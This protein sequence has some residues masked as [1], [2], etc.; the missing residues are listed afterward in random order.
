MDKDLSNLSLD[1]KIDFILSFR[2]ELDGHLNRVNSLA[3]VL[4]DVKGILHEI[5]ESTDRQKKTEYA[6]LRD[7]IA[8]LR[9]HLEASGLPKLD[10][11]ERRISFIRQKLDSP[12]WPVAVNPESIPT[13]EEDEH[14]RAGKIIDM[15]VHQ[16]PKD[17]KFLDF[18]CGAGYAV[19]A[20]EKREAA[21]AVGYDPKGG[22]RFGNSERVVFTKQM[23]EVAANGPYDIVLL[24]DVLDHLDVDPVGVLQSIVPHLNSQGRIYVRCHPWASKHGG[25]LYVQKNK[26]FLHLVLDEVELMRIGGIQ[27]DHILKIIRPLET[28]SE[29]FA[30]A[31]LKVMS[32]A[33][34]NEPMPPF[35]TDPAN[36]LI[37]GSIQKHWS[38]QDPVPHM[39][40]QYVDYVLEPDRSDKVIF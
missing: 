5:L 18:G 22:W 26:A 3:Q 39:T 19:M 28:Y 12:D 23:D 36:H 29:W 10:I 25:H 2:H 21:K 31:G 32:G 38:H 9:E 13:S 1:Q 27:S 8:I 34:R 35:F 16:Y 17:K 15:F 4:G 6:A 11:Y 14:D 24:W 30:K 40:L 7:E 37:M 20:A 33:P